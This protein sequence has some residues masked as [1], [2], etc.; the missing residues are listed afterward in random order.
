MTEC[1]VN[2]YH[3]VNHT[4]KS[5]ANLSRMLRESGSKTVKLETMAFDMKMKQRNDCM[6]MEK[7]KKEICYLRAEIERLKSVDSKSCD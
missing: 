4:Q 2:V 7:M 5:N 3:T 6:A 1:E